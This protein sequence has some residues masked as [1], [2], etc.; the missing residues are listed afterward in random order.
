MLSG[1]TVVHLCMRFT[2][3]LLLFLRSLCNVR[4]EMGG[5]DG[6]DLF[7]R[8]RDCTVAASTLFRTLLLFPFADRGGLEK[9]DFTDGSLETE[10]VFGL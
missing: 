4:C 10:A 2:I 6:G 7:D 3:S 8:N 5:T 9:L 1:G